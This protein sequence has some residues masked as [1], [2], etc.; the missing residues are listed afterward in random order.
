MTHLSANTA[1][2]NL[3]DC[4]LTR[5]FSERP[6]LFGVAGQLLTELWQAREISNHAP[7]TLFLSSKTSTPQQRFVRPLQHVLV[8]RF[9]R[10]QTLN[11]DEKQDLI[12]AA[13]DSQW[14]LDIDLHAVELLIN[15]CGPLVIEIYQQALIDYWN[16]AD[17][18]EQTPWQWYTQY[19]ADQYHSAIESSVKARTLTPETTHM[20]SLVKLHTAADAHERH[21]DSEHPDV[22]LL[23]L[24]LSEQGKLDADLAS[25][26]LIEPKHPANEHASLL[27]YTLTGQLTAFASRDAVFEALGQRWSHQPEWQPRLHLQSAPVRM[28]E[29]QARGLLDQQL[30]ALTSVADSCHSQ[31]EAVQL[32]LD[33]DRLTSMI[34]ECNSNEPANRQQLISQLPDWLINADSSALSRYSAMLSAVARGY[35]AANG[36]FWLDGVDD[37]EHFAYKKLAE[38][39]HADHPDNGLEPWDVEVI[40]HQ[41]EA[42]A[43]PGQD[44]LISDGTVTTVRFSLAQLAIGNLGLLKPGQVELKTHSGAQLPD[45]FSEDYLRTLISELDIATTYPHMLRSTLLS[46]DDQR[47]QRQ[48]LLAAQLATQMPALA[49]EHH[50]HGEHLSITAVD[51]ICQIFHHVTD[52]LPCA[53]VLRPLGFISEPGATPDQPQN[54]WLIEPDQAGVGCCVLYRPMATE[55]LLEFADRRALF[56]AIST[57]G[58]LQDDLLNRLPATARTIYAHGGF[59]EPH[60]P[61]SVEDSFTV[62]THTPAPP[63]L[64]TQAPLTDL[65]AT[66]Y[67]ACVEETIAHFE[68]NARSTSATRWARWEQLGWLLFNTL[69]PL[70]G[71]TL[72]RAAWLVQMETAFIQFVDAANKRDPANR[73]V[74]LANLL[75]SIAVLLLTHAHRPLEAKP[76]TT[77]PIETPTSQPLAPSPAQAAALD[78][79]WSQPDQRLSKAQRQALEQLQATLTTNELGMPII[80]G[81]QRGLYPHDDQLWVRLEDAVYRVEL[82]PH[83]EQPR[84]VN[85]TDTQSLGPWLCRD[86]QGRWQLDLGLRLRGGMPRNSRI[87]QRKAENELRLQELRAAF[88]ALTTHVP[89]RQKE[90]NKL[91]LVIDKFQEL[92][93]LSNAADKLR[94]LDTYWTDYLSTLKAKNE[95]IPLVNY[96]SALSLGLFQKFAIQWTKQKALI[97]IIALR[98]QKFDLYMDQIRAEAET[99][100][101]TDAAG[102]TTAENWREAL[103]ILDDMTPQLDDIVVSSEQLP[104]TREQLRQL[105]SNYRPEIREMN[106]SADQLLQQNPDKAIFYAHLLRLEINYE[107]LVLNPDWDSRTVVLLDHFWNNLDLFKSQ[108]L[109]LYALEDA[110]EDLK[111]QLLRDMAGILAGANRRLDNLAPELG[112]ARQQKIV[113]ALRKDLAFVTQDIQNALSDYPPTATV[114]Q[115]Q[116]QAPG[117][118]ET[119]DQGLLFGTPREGD[120]SLVDIYDANDKNRL[121][122][123]RQGQSGW[124]KVAEP[125]APVASAT[126]QQSWAR[127]LKKGEMLIQNSNKDLRFLESRAAWNYVPADIEDMLLHQ[128]QR[129]LSQRDAL[130]QRLADDTAAGTPV[131]DSA[132][133]MIDALGTQAQVLSEQAQVLRISVALKQPPRMGELEYLLQHNRVS[134]QSTGNRRL[135]PKVKGRLDDYFDEYE[136]RQNGE[137]LCYAHFH[138]LSEDAAKTAFV[139]GHLKTA[140]Q[141]YWRGRVHVDATTGQTTEVYRS[142]ISTAS[143][144]QYFF[145]L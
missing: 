133:Q 75:S 45:W 10:R 37:A 26:L 90:L 82:D 9:C 69:L 108:R 14:G 15:D 107:K 136:I 34:D 30:R 52:S 5:T 91:A 139:A 71:P 120:D 114:E 24:D 57:A 40:N 48:R 122:T 140:T 23:T 63:Q 144:K 128:Q 121:A 32:S 60:L 6:T 83:S 11:L 95:V 20:A 127:L 55:P 85:A 2:A 100:A 12:I 131:E 4:R 109:R 138:Y 43:I 81:A 76:Q 67:P 36:Q 49:M 65:I 89:E 94:T 39:L 116:Q 1:I 33:I 125:P 104:L 115:L 92:T 112:E 126:S 87:A 123:Y 53:W 79:S 22:S 64:S 99:A 129:V 54:T 93:I 88:D 68:A 47:Q 70:A 74:T 38:H 130:R 113:L 56:T 7:L 29:Q 31:Y 8:E 98:K 110:S 58:Q 42:A 61:F 25:A 118:I 41:V 106:L 13:P 96:K 119:R 103:Q 28:F 102:S 66:L 97:N 72:V 137:P 77:E 18:S 50:L 59:Q 117:L 86:Q 35:E 142:P 21:A 105:D 19:L 51:G 111:A 62:P 134:I 73:R 124:E 135:L 44:S 16:T 141:R 27:L 78:Y 3:F 80:S 143:A 84:I 145:N 101:L 46:D 132:Q 17:D